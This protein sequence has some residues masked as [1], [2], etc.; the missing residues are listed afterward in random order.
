ML[1]GKRIG[2][3]TNH[4]GVLPNGQHI[5]NA[6]KEK[7]DATISA[8][9]SP[10][11]GIRG[12]APAKAFVDNE[13]DP[14]TG[15]QV[16]SLYGKLMK[17]EKWMLDGIDALIYDIQDVGARFYTYI[18]TMALCM[19]AAAES[20]IGFIVL[21]RPMI[22]PG[23]L[24]DG[25]MLHEETQSYIG[26]LPVPV[27]YGL[28]PGE[29]A[30]LVQTEYLMPKG[31]KCRFQIYT[32]E[33]YSRSLWYDETGIPWRAPS[34]NIPTIEAAT[35]YP[36]TALLEGTNINEGRGT[37]HPFQYIG[38]PFID[39]DQFSGAL[40]TLKLPGIQIDPI[41]FTPRKNNAVS[42][43]R[44]MDE[45]C[46]GIY[47]T[48]SNRDEVKPV[49]TGIAIISA[50]KKLYPENFTFR[51]NGSFDKLISDTQVKRMIDDEC[52]Y[53]EIVATWRHGLADFDDARSKYFLYPQSDS[54]A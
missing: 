40:E 16:Y 36:G 44:F 54:R 34:P 53:A 13:V 43:V 12:D 10:E 27:V 29:L 18:S 8:L 25:P 30:G 28:T 49:E 5:V 52:D 47:I 4:S 15:I 17:P 9:F 7:S 39:K 2:V 6:I 42:H 3:I 31:L 22:A 14:E 32:L 41:D 51:A 33:D 37:P 20:G 11:H 48:V 21:D 50:L 19:E 45:L 24:L 38:A 26:M 23:R 1:S 35:I 46:H